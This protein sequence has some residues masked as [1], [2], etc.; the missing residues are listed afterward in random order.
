MGTNKKNQ[1][2]NYLLMAFCLIAFLIVLRPAF[3]SEK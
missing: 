2:I 3:R 1:I